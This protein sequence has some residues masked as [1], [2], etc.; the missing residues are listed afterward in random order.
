[1]IELNKIY[2][3]FDKLEVLKGINLNIKKGEVV[4]IIGLVVLENLRSL[5]V[6]IS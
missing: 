4:A 3:S 6:L 1:M 2:K 5:D